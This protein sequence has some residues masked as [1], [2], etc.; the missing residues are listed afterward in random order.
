MVFKQFSQIVVMPLII[1][2]CFWFKAACSSNDIRACNDQ[3]SIFVTSFTRQRNRFVRSQAAGW[4]KFV[5]QGEG[6][7]T[8]ATAANLSAALQCHCCPLE[9]LTKKT[10]NYILLYYQKCIVLLYSYVKLESKFF[11]HPEHKVTKGSSLRVSPL[12]YHGYILVWRLL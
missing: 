7:V 3:Y 1:F 11:S 9:I 2:S 5:T 4:V 12:T 8:E 6:G 10:N